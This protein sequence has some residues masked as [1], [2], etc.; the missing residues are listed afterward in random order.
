M[1]LDYRRVRCSRI[2]GSVH[3]YNLVTTWP[4]VLLKVTN[5]NLVYPGTAGVSVCVIPATNATATGAVQILD[6]NAPLTT[7]SLGGMAAP[8]CGTFTQG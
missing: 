4:A 8:G 5:T 2:I 7:L 1:N 3:A 6:G